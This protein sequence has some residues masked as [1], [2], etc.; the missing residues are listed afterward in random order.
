MDAL[1]LALQESSFAGFARNSVYFYPFANIVHVVAVIGFFGLVA[2]MDLRLLGVIGGTPAQTV[3]AKLR[4]I[5]LAALIVIAATGF[6]LFSAEA[7]ALARNPVFQIKL[8]AIALAL[9]NI[10]MN[11]WTLRRSGD[12]SGL[13]RATAGLS[14][15]AW[16]F[17]ATM[18]RTI[19]YV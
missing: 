5:A 14:L 7:V 19:A 1:W 11:D 13:A 18:G 12:A 15:F 16:L 17:I 10:A 6:I 3:I 4:P 8:S 9:I 2:T